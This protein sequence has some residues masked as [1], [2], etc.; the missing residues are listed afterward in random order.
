GEDDFY[1][2]FQ[3]AFVTHRDENRLDICACSNHGPDDLASVFKWVM[4]AF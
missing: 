2:I 1:R 3:Q 4:C